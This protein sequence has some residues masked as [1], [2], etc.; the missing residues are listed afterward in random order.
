MPIA[1]NFT[2]TTTL[3]LCSGFWIP[4]TS[5]S[6]SVLDFSADAATEFQNLLKQKV[7]TGTQDLK[8]AAIALSVDATL[9]TRNQRDFQRVPGLRIEDW[10]I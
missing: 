6:S 3:K 9:V 8:I 7:K 5:P 10:S 2:P 1:Q 4:I